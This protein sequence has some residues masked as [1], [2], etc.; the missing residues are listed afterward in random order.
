MTSPIAGGGRTFTLLPGQP[1]MLTEYAA[2]PNAPLTVINTSDDTIYVADS[3]SVGVAT[4]VPVAAGT[5][6]P[7]TQPGQIWAMLDPAATDTAP[8]VITGA[9]SNW[10]PSPAAIAAAVALELL[11]QGVPNVLIEKS[12]FNASI[13]NGTSSPNIDVSGYA[14]AEITSVL[15]PVSYLQLNA[16]GNVVDQE[17][18]GAGE[19]TRIAVVG[20]QLLITNQSGAATV[21]RVLASNRTALNRLDAR[22][23]ASNGDV[24]SFTNVT[25]TNGQPVPLV[26]L[27]PVQLQGL[28]WASFWVSAAGKGRFEITPPAGVLGGAAILA[29]TS[30]FVVDAHTNEALTD[31][32]LAVPAA[33]YTVQFRSAAAQTISGGCQFVPAS[34]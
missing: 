27:S 1:I 7:W 15:G 2:G 14:S 22:R 25:M 20:T 9:I 29:D 33:T 30:T 26:Q 4:G 19:A 5:A 16:I 32:L 13:A 6:I 11:Q 12:V 8:V 18:V 23:L 34:I 10:T 17:I 28:V 31:K 3:S 21:V 24:W